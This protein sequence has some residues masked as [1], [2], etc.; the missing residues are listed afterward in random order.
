MYYW[1]G[2][3]LSIGLLHN[4]SGGRHFPHK[5]TDFY[6]TENLLKLKTVYS[7]SARCNVHNRSPPPNQMKFT[8]LGRSIYVY[9]I[10]LLYDRSPIFTHKNVKNPRTVY[11]V[12][13]VIL[14]MHNR[15]QKCIGKWIRTTIYKYYQQLLYILSIIN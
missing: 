10:Y 7:P 2:P 11:G 12:P 6:L 1:P 4:L 9:C 3:P 14:R 5:I 13:T 8:T 15:W